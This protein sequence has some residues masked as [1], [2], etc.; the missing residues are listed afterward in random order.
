MRPNDADRAL[1]VMMPVYNAEKYLDESLNSALNQSFSDI[2]ILVINDGSSDNSK[3][4]AG[5][6]AT[7]DPRITLIEVPHRGL[8]TALNTGLKLSQTEWIARMDADDI[9]DPRRLE[10]Q[11]RFAKEHPDADVIAC[12]VDAFPEELV[13]EGFRRYLAW[14]NRSLTHDEIIAD[15]FR[16]SPICHPSV[17]IRRTTILQVGGYR[18]IDGPEDYDLWLRLAVIGARFA[19]LPDRLHHWRVH[20]GSLSRCDRRYRA[21]AFRTRRWSHLAGYLQERFPHMEKPLW[22]CGAGRAGR[23]LAAM[24]ERSGRTVAGSIDIDPRKIRMAGASGRV[25]PVAALDD[26]ARDGFFLFTA[27]NW[28]AADEFEILMAATGRRI[29]RDYLVV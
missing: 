14:Q 24:L 18:A 10:F 15:L 21:D 16:E 4:I 29:L 7:R 19:K 27:G 9:M 2:T 26:E 13:T 1:T 3:L 23:R 25:L 6:I 12:R 8:A 17:I 28:G 11:M 20:P 5:T 22:I